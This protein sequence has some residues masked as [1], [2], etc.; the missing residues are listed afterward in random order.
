MLLSHGVIS[1]IDCTLL[2]ELA[3]LLHLH[4]GLFL[5]NLRCQV[6]SQNLIIVVTVKTF[7]LD[8]VSDSQVT[9]LLVNRV[10]LLKL[11]VSIDFSL[12]MVH[13]V[14][15]LIVLIGNLVLACD[16]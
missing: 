14:P 4:P 3:L 11:L 5:L 2:F 15:C 16:I 8:S 12:C 6:S 9:S 13:L 1:V 7:G 10:K